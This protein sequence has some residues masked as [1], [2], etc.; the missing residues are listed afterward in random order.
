MQRNGSI[1][2]E[3]SNLEA[4]LLV[5]LPRVLQ[6]PSLGAIANINISRDRS[7]KGCGPF[8]LCQ[9]TWYMIKHA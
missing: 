5:A 3:L 8:V 7:E 1:G 4:A 2:F 6:A 9:P